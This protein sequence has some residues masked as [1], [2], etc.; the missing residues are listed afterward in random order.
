MSNERDNDPEAETVLFL[1][2]LPFSLQSFNDRTPLLLWHNTALEMTKKNLRG[3]V[4]HPQDMIPNYI[5]WVILS[6]LDIEVYHFHSVV[7]QKHKRQ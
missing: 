3:T 2:L 6:A 4:D 7:A 1:H 5:G